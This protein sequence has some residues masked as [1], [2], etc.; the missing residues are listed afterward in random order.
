VLVIRAQASSAPRTYALSFTDGAGSTAA[1]DAAQAGTVRV[2]PENSFARQGF[3]FGGWSYAGGVYQPGDRFAQPASDTVMTALWIKQTF[4]AGGVVADETAA[5]V[6]NAVV[7]LMSGSR[8]IGQPV[9]TD[10]EGTYRFADVTPGTY[11]LVACFNGKVKTVKVVIE[12]ADV[13]NNVVLPLGRTNSVVVVRAG[14]PDIVVG[15]L[16]NT[17]TDDTV[18]TDANKTTVENGGTV[19]VKLTAAENT[20]GNS[21][22]L[23]AVTKADANAVVGIYIDLDL[24][25]SVWDANGNAIPAQS[26]SLDESGVLLETIIPLPG[27]LQGKNSYSVSR[28]HNGAV[29]TL[30]E[31]LAGANADGEYFTVNAQRTV[32][33]VVAKK[34]STY[35][36]SYVNRRSAA[37]GGSGTYAVTVAASSG[38][39]AKADK[40]EAAEGEKVTI[41][42]SADSG[43]RLESLTAADEKGN[44]V[45]LTNNGGGTYVFVMPAGAVAVK[46]VFAAKPWAPDASG[47]ASL[48]ETEDHIRYINGYVDR[49]VGPGRKMTR[50]EAAQMFYNLLRNKTAG[51][52]PSFRDVASGAWYAAAVRSLAS[53]GIVTG[54][55]DGSF[56]PNESITREQFCAM[57]VRFASAPNVRYA[58]RFTDVTADM[59]SYRSV[60]T[61]AAMGWINGYGDGTFGPKG[62]ITRAEVVTI[63]NHMLGRSADRSY[64][65]AHA[66]SLAAFGDLTDRTKWY[67]YDMT[68]AANAHD[69][70]LDAARDETWTA[71]GLGG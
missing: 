15:N 9:T 48:L 30:R 67:Y 52:A 45:A 8:Q 19:E 7:T 1:L 3:A 20:A 10:D 34:Y 39:S 41:T 49:T 64:V 47:V 13:T 61:A 65:D 6:A 31:G 27:E 46:P 68:E 22:I 25:R 69:Y 38:G 43:S 11:D 21:D 36:I 37:G 62:T 17:F 29:E 54:Y 55:G 57:A 18:Y 58:A 4:S 63:V 40:T 28:Q 12:A 2:L 44:A 5:P 59:W 35:A 53:L 60:M 71:A 26:A 56:R 70:T 33:T 32:V 16:E 66:G 24:G 50:A 14:T 51:G 23:A 42:V